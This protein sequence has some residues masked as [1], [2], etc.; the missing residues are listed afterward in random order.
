MKFKTAA[1]TAWLILTLPLLAA[2]LLLLISA[3]TTTGVLFGLG[4]FAFWIPIPILLA[5][6]FRQSPKRTALSATACL[7]GMS[8]LI[9][10]VITS[11]RLVSNRHPDAGLHSEYSGSTRF[12]RWNPANLVPEVDQLLM[13]TRLFTLLDP[14][15]TS[16][17]ARRTRQSVRSVYAEMRDD[18]DFRNIPS[19]LGETYREIF[20]S[21]PRIGHRFVYLPTTPPSLKKR[22]PVIVF[23]HGSLGN[24]K[25][26]LWT[27][28]PLADQKD[29]AIVAPTFGIGEWRN[30]QGREAILSTL[31]YCRNRPDFDSDRI[32]LA[33]I[34]NGG[35]GITHILPHLQK[36]IVAGLIYLS[37]VIDPEK[38]PLITPPQFAGTPALV[39]SGE[40]DRRVPPSYVRRGA[41]ALKSRGFSV[42]HSSIERE[43]HFL[44]FS[45]PERVRLLIAD[46]LVEWGVN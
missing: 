21:E 7:L 10:V 33:G 23:L 29:I 35:A 26:Y 20:F 4:I 18:P 41:D 8:L 1:E 37:P 24:F 16:E 40:E 46:W 14:H 28:K 31:E 3:V 2:V 9:G 17:Q 42:R 5:G 19:A 34:S 30:D 36:G 22:R 44:L 27:L 25:G 38:I 45:Q 43:D 39:I 11:P 15:L 6:N 32:F 13:G 12:H